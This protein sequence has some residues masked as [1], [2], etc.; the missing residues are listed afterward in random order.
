MSNSEQTN[1][2]SPDIIE[3]IIPG[4]N[5]DYNNKSINQNNNN[6]QKPFIE[7]YNEKESALAVI[8]EATEDSTKS[9]DRD[10][11]KA[12]NQISLNTTAIIDA[13]EQTKTTKEITENYLELQKY[14]IDSFQSIF[15]PYFQNVQNQFWSNQEFFQGISKMYYRWFNNY[16]ENMLTFSKKWNN[17]AF[18]KAGYFNS[19]INKATR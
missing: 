1:T 17:I 16:A 7:N 18:T 3:E 13:Q 19:E 12:Q 6:N 9:I 10:T 5:D 15:I 11:D 2:E 8:E 14:N 4:K